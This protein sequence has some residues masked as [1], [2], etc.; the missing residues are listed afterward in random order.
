M[1]LFMPILHDLPKQ[2]RPREKLIKYGPNKLSNHE[3]LAII[4]G[5]GRKGKNVLELAKEVLRKINKEELLTTDVLT[6][7]KQAG[8][9]L[10]KACQL[11]SCFEL[12]KRFL[13]EKKS[14][15]I[16]KPEDIWREMKEIRG[17]KKEYLVIFY[18]DVRNQV[19][20]KEIISI[21]SL[22]SSLIH[23]RE[24]FEPAVSHLAAQIIISHNHPSGDPS[25]SEEDIEVTKR[26]IQ[27]G[28]ILGIEIIDHVIVTEKEFFSM[29]EKKII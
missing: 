9:G 21:G 19:I 28:E 23:P 8:I 24:V 3:L 11:I 10:V 6:L 29:K 12:G 16:M 20:R 17:N 27:V 15:L 4:L 25:P 18:L 5:S 22:N 2:D 1:D 7:K 13:K 14:T 26:L